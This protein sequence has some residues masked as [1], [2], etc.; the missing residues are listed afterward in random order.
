MAS[1]APNNPKLSA[2]FVFSPDKA[3]AFVAKHIRANHGDLQA[4]AASLG[5]SRMTMYRWTE[6][7]RDLQ[8]AV[9]RARYEE[10]ERAKG[11]R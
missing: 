1:A 11:R 9:D 7:Y 8:V 6:R 5:V 4:T 3:I 2:M 10:T